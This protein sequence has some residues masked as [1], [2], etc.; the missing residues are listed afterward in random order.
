M[1]SHKNAILSLFPVLGVQNL[2]CPLRRGG[3]WFVSLK[4]NKHCAKP[5]YMREVGNPS[6]HGSCS[7][8]WPN[9]K[10]MLYE[11]ITSGIALDQGKDHTTWLL[12]F[13]EPQDDEQGQFH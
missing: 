11:Y 1:T 7:S 6:P 4:R 10:T 5:T 3:S 13:R 2:T 8:D 12:A 9:K